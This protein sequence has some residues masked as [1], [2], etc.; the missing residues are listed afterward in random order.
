MVKKL[1]K[2]LQNGKSQFSVS[3]TV[4]IKSSTFPEKD[5]NGNLKETVSEKSGFSY[6]RVGFP[7]TAS[8]NQSVYV[9][10][11]GGHN[12]SS[13]EKD[14]VYATD[15]ETKKSTKIKWNLRN[16]KEVL[17]KLADWSFIRI[18]IEKDENGKLIEKRFLSAID[19]I[20]YL[21]QHLQDKMNVYVSGTVDY[22]EYQGEIQRN[23]NVSQ[24]SLNEISEDNEPRK[25]AKMKQTY[26]VD[27]KALPKKW[28][29][30]LEENGKVTL[31]LYVPQYE[32][33]NVKKVVPLAQDV[34]V[35][36]TKERLD[37]TK[38]LIKLLFI[39]SGKAVR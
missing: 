5:E 16:N 8:D 25:F 2:E 4:S 38:K 24:I 36:T 18:R 10:L 21:E 22:S 28:E 37:K 12:P 15:A 7:V 39:P 33:G 19:A 13:P 23:Y 34:T 20:A 14:V 32:G 31:A 6:M 26:L 29:N 30:E 9:T 1:E 27:D 35:R 3:G 17:S 11:F